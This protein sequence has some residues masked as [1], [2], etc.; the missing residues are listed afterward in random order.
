MRH[1]GVLPVKLNK[2]QQHQFLH[3]RS[4]TDAASKAAFQCV[5]TAITVQLHK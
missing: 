1:D 5:N 3:C 4:G 2:Y